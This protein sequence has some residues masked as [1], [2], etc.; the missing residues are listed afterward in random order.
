LRHST[1]VVSAFALAFVLAGCTG[2]QQTETT[3]SPSPA[4][5]VTT[6]PEAAA[7]GVPTTVPTAV[8]VTT[9][10]PPSGP[11][12]VSTPTPTPNP[13][14]LDVA[15]GTILRSYSP[16][17]IDD[18]NDGNLGNYAVN[19]SDELPA[20]ATPPY[21]FVFEFPGV[22]T[23]SGFTA[24]MANPPDTGPAPSVTIAVSTTSATS[25]FTDVG[26]MTSAPSA[27]KTT[28][29][30]NVKARWVRVIANNHLY[31]QIGATGTIAP[32]PAPVD[33]TGVYI[34]DARPDK[35]GAL[36]MSGIADGDWRARFVAVGGGL[37]A[38]ECSDRELRATFVGSFQGR[39]WVGVSGANKDVNGSVIRASINDEGTIIVGDYPNG[40]GPVYFLRT[41][42]VPKFCAPRVTG[43]GLHHFLVL[44]QDRQGTFWPVDAD[45]PLP[46]YQFSAIGAGMLDGTSLA[47]QEGVISRGMCNAPDIM[48]PEQIATLNS[49][50]AAGHKLILGTTGCNDP[51]RSDFSWLPYQATVPGPGPGSSNASLIQVESDA[52]GSND[53]NDAAHFIDVTAYVANANNDLPAAIPITSTDTHWCG[54]F[55]TAKTTNLNG[56]VQS[57]AVDGTGLI[58]Y[59]GFNGLDA[60]FPAL[61]RIRQLE[62]AAPVPGAQPCSQLVTDPFILEPSQ[63]AAFSAGKAQKVGVPM[64]VLANQGWNGHVTVKA[65]GDIPTTVSPA[66]FDIAGGKQPIAVSVNVPA[67]Q[68][69]GVYT[70]TVAADNGSGKKAQATVS[71]TGTAAPAA[72]KKQFKT[73]KRIRIYGIHFDVDSAHIQPRSEPVIADIAQTMRETPGLRFQVE[74]H[75]DS[76]GGAAYNL[77]LSQRRAQAVVDDLVTHYKIARSRLVAKGYGLTRPVAPNTT[78]AGKALN[79][80]VELLRL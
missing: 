1:I 40:G 9:A 70:V 57:Y 12:P 49:W 41:T 54:H 73:Q 19:P 29:S 21:T 53:R 72:I 63:E 25:G 34:E 75:T 6:S 38:T 10:T 69:P 56:F 4:V 2:H 35:N 50:V 44:D 17:Q 31:Y 61:Q 67:S 5:T 79:R 59:D 11:T 24:T 3:A 39:T 48:G 71:L 77:G 36:Q 78:P 37:T 65:T 46:G 42:V 15:N 8:A 18:E 30:A 26:T 68:K 66:A 33:P 52:L 20:T 58:V 23:I 62:L 14:L 27:T 74:G 16:P 55:F 45:P 13:N 7:S 43:T 80:R 22:A 60:G 64:S 32:P 47:G 51:T 76:D 28:L